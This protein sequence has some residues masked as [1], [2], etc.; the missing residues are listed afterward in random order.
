MTEA[1]R[2]AAGGTPGTITFRVARRSVSAP[3]LERS[4]LV[5]DGTA[6]RTVTVPHAPAHALREA[7]ITVLVRLDRPD[8]QSGVFAKDSASTARA[9]HLWLTWQQTRWRL[10]LQTPAN[11]TLLGPTVAAPVAGTVYHVAIALGPP[12]CVLYVDGVEVRA[13]ATPIAL[14]GQSEPWLL[15]GTRVGATVLPGPV[16]DPMTGAV[17]LFR[18]YPKRLGAAEVARLAAQ[19]LRGEPFDDGTWFTDG[20]GWRP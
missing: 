7:T 19:E 3:V 15:G 13:A 6:A 4:D 2:V 18:V 5:F 9:G 8:Q 17:L 20:T 10:V 11:V 12:A 1:A 14:D 16:A